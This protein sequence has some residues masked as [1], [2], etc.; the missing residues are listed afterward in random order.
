MDNKVMLIQTNASSDERFSN[1]YQIV[2]NNID[3]IKNLEELL[4]DH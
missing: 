4:N 3:V 1:G 2:N